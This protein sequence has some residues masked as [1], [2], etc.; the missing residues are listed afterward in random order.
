MSTVKYSYVD[1][2]GEY[3]TIEV[4]QLERAL[5]IAAKH[6]ER[7][8]YIDNIQVGSKYYS[9]DSVLLLCNKYDLL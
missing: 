1:E 6:H 5:Y 8:Y 2:M 9:R 3:R 7:G 4:D